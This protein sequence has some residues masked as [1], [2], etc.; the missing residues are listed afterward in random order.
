MS[1][2]AEKIDPTYAL[3][4]YQAAE[5]YGVK[6]M[7]P[8]YFEPRVSIGPSYWGLRIATLQDGRYLAVSYDEDHWIAAVVD[9]EEM[10]NPFADE[11]QPEYDGN[12]MERIANRLKVGMDWL[13]C[14]RHPDDDE[15]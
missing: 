4:V 9:D 2:Y 7:N 1:P 5:K 15:Y 3:V 14:Y 6:I 10:G 13:Y 12:A 8:R 11:V